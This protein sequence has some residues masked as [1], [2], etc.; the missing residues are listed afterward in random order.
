[1][2]I[3]LGENLWYYIPK[4]KVKRGEIMK[5]SL[6]GDSIRLLGYGKETEKLL[7]KDFEVFQPEEN[8]RFAKYTLRG[9]YE[10]RKNMKGSEIVH[11][12]V[13][14]WDTCTLFDNESFTDLDE[15]VKNTVKIAK[16]LKD[17]YGKV[18]F[19]TT[20]PVRQGK[21]DNNNAIIDKYNA[22]VVPELSKMGVRINDLNALVRQDVD[23][24]ICDDLI[25]LSAE[26]IELCAKAVADAIK[27]AAKE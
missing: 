8:C 26:G 27:E 2:V 17:N 20:T 24:Y 6:L 21:P 9:I 14:L 25:H 10:W 3:A 16:I 22:A 7:G 15:Y 13:G 12:N 11:F 19:A 4:E 18:I 5:I 1:M 23:R